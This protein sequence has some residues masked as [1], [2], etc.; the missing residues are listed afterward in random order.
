MK[1]L[2][3]SIGLVVMVGLMGV[4]SEPAQA[5]TETV[6]L[7]ICKEN[8]GKGHWE[9]SL[10][11]K[12]KASGNWDTREV[13]ETVALTSS[14]EKLELIDTK[15][16]PE[17]RI[18]CNMTDKGWIGVHGEGGISSV[19]FS[20]CARVEGPCEAGHTVTV[21]PLTLGWDYS[22]LR[23]G[24]GAGP[25]I[26]IEFFW[27]KSNGPGYKIECTVS[28]KSVVAD[29]CRG[30]LDAEGEQLNGTVIADFAEKIEGLEYPPK[31]ECT[32]GGAEAG[33][34]R[35]KDVLKQENGHGLFL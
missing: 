24:S 4:A 28:E 33:E 15:T 26:W 9:N 29:E 5:T 18:T 16:K 35:G 1:Y 19:T 14:A 10:C 34:I 23:R 13:T 8:A 7:A 6:N 12:A 17:S 22:V 30:A 25:R 31:Q 27:T 21:T 32:S 2:K 3:I 20:G 11:T